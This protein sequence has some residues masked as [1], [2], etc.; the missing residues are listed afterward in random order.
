M[1]KYREILRM[2]S[3]D[4]S[5]HMIAETLQV[6]R[7]TVRKVVQTALDMH[8][9]WTSILR[10]GLE[11]DQVRNRLFPKEDSKD[12]FFPLNCE[13]MQK[14]LGKTGVSLQILWLEYSDKARC[15]GKRAYK[16]S[17][18]CDIYRE[19]SQESRATMH[20][21][22]TPGRDVEVD[23]AGKTGFLKDPATGELVPVYIF[24]AT[25]SYSQYSYAEGF[26]SMDLDSWLTAHIHLFEFLGGVPKNIIPDNLKT[27]VKKPSF[28]EPEIQKNYQELAEHYSTFI[29]PARVRKPRDKANV[30]AAVNQ[31][32]N[33]LLGKVRNQTFF[34]LKEFNQV[35]QAH[36]TGFNTH[37]FQKKT[38]SRSTLFQEEKDLLTPLP[39]MRYEMAIWKIA[40]V[41]TNYH[42]SVNGMFYS[43]PFQYIS[44]KLD[45]KITSN[46]IQIFQ[47]EKRIASHQRKFGRPGQYSNVVEHMPDKHQKALEWDRSIPLLGREIW[48][49]YPPDDSLAALCA[50]HPSASISLMHGDLELGQKRK[51]RAAGTNVHQGSR[52]YKQPK[53]YTRQNGL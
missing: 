26:L 16:Y 2:A 19:Y 28:Y 42:I 22:R 29:I 15:M 44:Q 21:P 18:F 9:D 36:I 43:V 4:F 8:L 27:G 33:N 45:V 52:A 6:S 24:V 17:R 23:W 34:T 3:E 13:Y 46:L 10:Q 32:A 41:Q 12:P 49:E 25:M 30:E 40:T 51:R 1:T 11:E 35:V 39:K 47:K 50:P 48:P 20:I 31:V 7:N 37:A 14:E 53:L 5:Q 38:G